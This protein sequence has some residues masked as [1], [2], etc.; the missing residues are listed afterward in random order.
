[1]SN[2]AKQALAALREACKRCGFQL[3]ACGGCANYRTRK[4][5]EKKSKEARSQPAKPLFTV[6]PSKTEAF[7]GSAKKHTAQMALDRA[8]KHRA[9]AQDKEAQP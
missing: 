5:L 2:Q 4:A 9:A 7:F 3:R 6:D 8:A 1:M